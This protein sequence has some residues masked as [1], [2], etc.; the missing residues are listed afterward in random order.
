MVFAGDRRAAVVKVGH[1]FGI[2]DGQ[3]SP[4]AIY[5][6]ALPVDAAGAAVVDDL[7]PSSRKVRQDL[8]WRRVPSIDRGRR[9]GQI[10]YR[11]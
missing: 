5:G 9:R 6:F 7:G 8:S 11:R 10:A 3:V 2:A 4:K 1:H